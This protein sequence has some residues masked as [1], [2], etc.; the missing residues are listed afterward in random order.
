MLELKL[1]ERHEDEAYLDR[2]VDQWQP[3]DDREVVPIKLQDL[4][5]AQGF[6]YE[7]RIR[8]YADAI[9]RGM[10]PPPIQ[11]LRLPDGRV[12]LLDGHHRAQ[13]WIACGWL[14]VP[15]RVQEPTD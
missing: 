10:L 12:Y 14:Q 8:F 15:M 3:D 7:D 2:L 4:V 9:R 6:L 11:G 13:A 5:H 1:I